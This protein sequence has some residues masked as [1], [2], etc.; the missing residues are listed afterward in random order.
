[1]NERHLFAGCMGSSPF[2]NPI[3]HQHIGVL[4]QAPVALSMRMYES[5]IQDNR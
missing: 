1:M 3:R 4:Y 5:E 2:F